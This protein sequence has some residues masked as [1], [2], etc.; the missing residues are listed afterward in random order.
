MSK[1][2]ILGPVE[3]LNEEIT[4]TDPVESLPI[5]VRS[6]TNA[7]FQIGYNA[8]GG[9]LEGSID[10]YASV[11]G[12]NFEDMGLSITA[13][14]G[15]AG[16]AVVNLTT[17]GITYVKAVIIPTAGTGTVIVTASAKG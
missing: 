16:N 17:L 9:T 11:D 2:R 5:D 12:T 6:M 10:I 15:V 7:A 14:A 1:F 4:G 13:M 8:G 3:R